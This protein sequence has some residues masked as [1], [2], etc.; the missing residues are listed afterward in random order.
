MM[1]DLSC[2]HPRVSGKA[3]SM[4]QKENGSG[5]LGLT[6]PFTAISLNIAIFAGFSRPKIGFVK[7]IPAFISRGR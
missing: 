4:V 3:L 1:P 6:E 5:S 2:C 7:I